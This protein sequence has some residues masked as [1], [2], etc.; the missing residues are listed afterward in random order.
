MRRETVARLRMAATAQ[1]YGF[2]YGKLRAEVSL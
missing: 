1:S 2:H